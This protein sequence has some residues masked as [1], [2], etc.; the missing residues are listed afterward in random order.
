MQQISDIYWQKQSYA[1][2]PNQRHIDF[3]DLEHIY[4]MLQMFFELDDAAAAAELESSLPELM[5]TLNFYV[6]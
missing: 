4:Q 2:G 1:P 3:R 5:A 6:E